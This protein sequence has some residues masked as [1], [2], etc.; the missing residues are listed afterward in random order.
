[1]RRAIVLFPL[2]AWISFVSIHEVSAFGWRGMDH[3]NRRCR[4]AAA[5]MHRQKPH[6]DAALAAKKAASKVAVR[7]DQDMEEAEAD[8]QDALKTLVILMKEILKM[9]ND[10]LD[11]ELDSLEEDDSF[12]GSD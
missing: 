8:E 1:M 4:Y 3:K 5:K 9:E 7:P 12:Y 6:T 10:R 2:L 11:R